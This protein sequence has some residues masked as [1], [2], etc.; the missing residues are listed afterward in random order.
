MPEIVVGVVAFAAL[1]LA[2]ALLFVIPSRD[3]TQ[4]PGKRLI[5]WEVL[6]P[7]TSPAWG[8]LMGFVVLAWGFLVIQDVFLFWLGSP[9]IIASLAI[10][11]LQFSYGVP[12]DQADV[13]RLIN[14]SW[15]WL[16]LAPAVL[17]AVNLVLVLRGRRT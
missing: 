14:P 13:L 15:V 4:P 17:F 2:I 1:L 5:I 9:Y 6:I 12:A 8:P 7:G 16:Y 10:P 11:N 3:V